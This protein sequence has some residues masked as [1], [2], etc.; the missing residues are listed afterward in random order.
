M[1]LSIAR[2]H[3]DTITLTV[4]TNPPQGGTA[5]P[6]GT[7]ARGSTPNLNIQASNGWYISNVTLIP[8]G[9]LQFVTARVSLQING[10]DVTTITNDTENT[11]RLAPV[12]D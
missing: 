9:A 2:S 4:I 1:F 5:G 6:A 8:A 10:G 12:S 7:Y 3:A 11:G